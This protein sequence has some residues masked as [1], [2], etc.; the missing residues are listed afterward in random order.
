[1]LEIPE[2]S[3]LDFMDE[4]CNRNAI[5][6]VEKVEEGVVVRLC[7]ALVSNR[8]FESHPDRRGSVIDVQVPWQAF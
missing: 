6:V 7:I 3:L 2:W 5:R 4:T 8:I 1:M